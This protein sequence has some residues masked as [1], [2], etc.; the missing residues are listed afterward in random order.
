MFARSFFEMNETPFIH[1]LDE[2]ERDFRYFQ[3]SGARVHTPAGTINMLQ[4]RFQDP[5]PRL[6]AEH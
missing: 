4:P 3:Q 1:A 5:L 2:D 6:G